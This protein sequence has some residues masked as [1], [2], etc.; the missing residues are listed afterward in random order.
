MNIL[1]FGYL[2][3]DCTHEGS[4]TIE[5]MRGSHR[6]MRCSGAKTDGVRFRPLDGPQKDPHLQNPE[7]LT[8]GDQG[9][10]PSRYSADHAVVQEEAGTVVVFQNG[11]WHRALAT[12]SAAPR[13]IVFFGYCPTMLRPLHR[14]L[15]YGGD[16]SGF[17][18]EERFLLHEDKPPARWIYGSPRDKVRMDRFR[19]QAEPGSDYFQRKLEE[20]QERI[21]ELEDRL[22][23]FEVVR[24]P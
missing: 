8:A 23:S 12:T 7:V 11:C 6:A 15:P 3:S 22:E 13:S 18:D 2:T 19:R 17:T 14:P 20:A 16:A 24:C 4:G 1:R 10:E 5:F 9:T 21:L